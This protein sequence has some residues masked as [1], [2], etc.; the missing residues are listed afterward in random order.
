M[1]EGAVNGY[2]E[3][4]VTLT[5]RGPTG[6]EG[7]F[8]FVVDTG[9]DGAM[10]LHPSIAAALELPR[11]GVEHAMLA[12]GSVA[13]FPSSAVSVLWNGKLRRVSVSVAENVPFLGMAALEGHELHL[14]AIT[15]GLVRISAL[16]APSS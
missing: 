16:P 11:L 12:D 6:Q 1:I 13:V 9:F 14:Q 4:V 8:D 2:G 3:A 15:D 7:R 10:S 5:V